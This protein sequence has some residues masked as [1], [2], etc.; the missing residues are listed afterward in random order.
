[1][2]HGLR[3]ISFLRREMDGTMVWHGDGILGAVGAMAHARVLSPGLA[4][5][6]LCS[7]TSSPCHISSWRCWGHIITVGTSFQCL[8]LQMRVCGPRGHD[9]P[10][11][12]P[13]RCWTMIRG[14]GP[15][16]EEEDIS[17]FIRSICR[18]EGERG[19]GRIIVSKF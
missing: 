2:R 5:G 6:P 17:V 10:F 8:P 3:G 15:R 14:W 7:K 4:T 1:L 19:E 9:H 12:R 18:L 13:H 16:H 11:R